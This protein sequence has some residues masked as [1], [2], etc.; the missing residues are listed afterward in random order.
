MNINES[1]LA[2]ETAYLAVSQRRA[3]SLERGEVEQGDVDALSGKHADDPWS[4]LCTAPLS[5]RAARPRTQS[6][7]QI[8]DHVGTGRRQNARLTP[9]VRHCTQPGQTSPLVQGV[10][11]PLGSHICP[12]PS[13]EQCLHYATW[14]GLASTRR[15]DSCPTRLIALYKYNNSSSSSIHNYLLPMTSLHSYLAA[16]KI[17]GC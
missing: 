9:R 11:G 6:V 2:T 3:S 17:A 12:C 7:G 5:L 8:A 10:P 13:T 15:S 14:D 4:R 16:L 1:A